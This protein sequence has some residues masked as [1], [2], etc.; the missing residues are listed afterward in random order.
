M[1]R[2]PGDAFWWAAQLE[3]ETVAGILNRYREVERREPP[4][5]L[6]EATKGM[7]R[8]F[9]EA[10]ERLYECDNEPAGVSLADV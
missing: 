9:R 8:R 7:V 5:E 3:R 1:K 2:I 4:P 10:V 6:A